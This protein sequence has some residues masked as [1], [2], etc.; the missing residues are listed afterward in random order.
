MQTIRDQ[1]LSYATAKRDEIV[2][3]AN[4]GADDDL[5]EAERPNRTEVVPGCILKFS[6]EL[7]I[8]GQTVLYLCPGRGLGWLYALTVDG[9]TIPLGSYDVTSVTDRL[10][11]DPEEEPMPIIIAPEPEQQPA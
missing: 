11:A 5:P 3:N 8:Y 2:T 9:A 7:D 4:N 1:L 10:P 6:D